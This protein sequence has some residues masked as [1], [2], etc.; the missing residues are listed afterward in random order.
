MNQYMAYNS[1]FA[2]E[3]DLHDSEKSPK[4]CASGSLNLTDGLTYYRGQNEAKYRIGS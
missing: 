1:R 2:G 4:P 3:F